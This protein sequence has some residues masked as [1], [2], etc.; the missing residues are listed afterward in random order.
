MI[1]D[2]LFDLELPELSWCLPPPAAAHWR[3]IDG[4]KEEHWDNNVCRDSL[5]SIDLPF[6]LEKT[7]L[8]STA[9]QNSLA[10]AVARA[11]V[12]AWCDVVESADLPCVVL[13]ISLIRIG[14]WP[15]SPLIGLAILPGCRGRRV[16]FEP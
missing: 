9:I 3:V 16:P 15:R 1:A 7:Y 5:V 10:V 4:M 11:L 13:V 14:H 12:L 8:L 2:L 6:H